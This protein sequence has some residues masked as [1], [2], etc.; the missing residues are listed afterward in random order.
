VLARHQSLTDPDHARAAE[1]LSHGRAKLHVEQGEVEI[2][3]RALTDHDR[4][5][6]LDL[7]GPS[8]Q[9]GSLEGSE[10]LSEAGLSEGLA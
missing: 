7:S 10:G 6:G 4:V 1:V 8:P 2:E 9:G 5:L 3:Q